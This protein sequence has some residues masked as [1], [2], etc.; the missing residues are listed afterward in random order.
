VA[1]QE[2]VFPHVAVALARTIREFGEQRPEARGV[3]RQVVVDPRLELG[4]Q[5]GDEVA[6]GAEMIPEIAFAD[7]EP[8]GD[9]GERHMCLAAL[10]EQSESR[11]R[12]S[13]PRLHRRV[14]PRPNTV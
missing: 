5:R 10:V 4:E 9:L 7:A 2:A 13:V 11:R 14:A 3:A 8:A 12:N 6:L 1:V